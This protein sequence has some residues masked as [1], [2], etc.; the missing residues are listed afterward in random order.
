VQ[1]V[2]NLATQQ[3]EAAYLISCFVFFKKIKY[4]AM[5]ISIIIFLS[6]QNL[7]L[8]AQSPQKIYRITYKVR[9]IEAPKSSDTTA[10][11]NGKVDVNN[12]Q[13]LSAEANKQQYLQLL[14]IELELY[15]NTNESLFMLKDGLMPDQT[16]LASSIGFGGAV[17]SLGMSEDSK[18]YKNVLRKIGIEQKT[19]RGILY[20][21][22]QPYQKYNWTIM[23]TSKIILGHLC[24][25]ATAN[26]EAY[27][28][29]SQ[30]IIRYVET[31]WFTKD[32]ALPFGPADFEGLPG[33][34][35]EATRHNGR[36]LYAA[37]IK[38]NYIDK[39]KI[40]Q[41]PQEGKEITE[42]EYLKMLSLGTEKAMKS[43]QES[44][45]D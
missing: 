43:Y 21:I 24:F 12:I 3:N 25:K 8:F 1:I 17:I 20:K 42:S 30:S 22:S 9:P 23:D 32:F 10:K 31:A 27:N 28:R 6:I 40:L 18:R 35:L 11:S 15:C 44:K 19:S 29:R 16:D 26:W 38:E 37:E 5:K 2:D 7:L 33:L 4:F 14:D 13:A 34:V 45:K 39:K 41:E 36:T